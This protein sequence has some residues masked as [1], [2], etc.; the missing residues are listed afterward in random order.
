MP[1]DI[2][3]GIDGSTEGLAAAHWAAQEAQ[4]RGAGL[5]VIHVWYRHPHPAPYVPMDSTE[6]DWAEQLL[7]EAVRSIGAAHPGLR[8]ADRLVCD[9]TVTALL[10]AG[11]DA[12]LLVLGSRGLGAL[13]GFLTGSVSQRVVGRSTRPVVLVRAARS[14]ADEHLPAT[15]GVAPE[16]IPKTPYRQVVLGLQT[17]RP[18]DE[19]IEFA[20]DAARRR[21]TGLR[22][23]HALR[24]AFRPAPVAPA[25][26]VSV[27]AEGPAP[28]PWPQAQALAD[29]ERTVA[30]VLRPWREKYPTVPVTETVT[31][32]RA[33]VVLVRAARDAGLLVVGRRGIDH[34]VGVH[35][36]PVTH[37]VLHH[38][39]CP[40]AVVPHD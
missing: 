13:G 25:P 4:R 26:L 17:D 18:C 15:D 24:T 27:T 16:E 21:G 28:V 34:Q 39:R 29:E 12:D 1:H 22:V 23:V 35:T 40:V 14:A 6:R 5:S 7:R 37:A 20:F 30:A 32:G 2:V 36:G 9:A 8:I 10:K 19:L 31:E 33:A 38:A 3:V 11:A